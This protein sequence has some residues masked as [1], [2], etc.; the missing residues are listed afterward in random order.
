MVA[1]SQPSGVAL[2]STV[3]V[4]PE[5]AGLCNNLPVGGATA[6]HAGH[7]LQGPNAALGRKTKFASVTNRVQGL[8]QIEFVNITAVSY[9]EAAVLLSCQ[10]T[11]SLSEPQKMIHSFIHCSTCSSNAQV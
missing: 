1:N 7:C 5:Q 6:A 3:A 4:Q 9:L 8:L 10:N 11:V 2:P